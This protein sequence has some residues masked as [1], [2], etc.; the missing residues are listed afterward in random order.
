MVWGGAREFCFND[1]SE[2]PECR[3]FIN[4]YVLYTRMLSP[5]QQLR[6]ENGGKRRWDL[7][8]MGGGTVA[9]HR[10]PG[11]FLEPIQTQPSS[12]EPCQAQVKVRSCA[13]FLEIRICWGGL[14]LWLELLHPRWAPGSTDSLRYHSGAHKQGAWRKV[15]GA[16]ECEQSRRIRANSAVQLY[17]A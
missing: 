16:L 2:G 7:Q 17:G 3:C 10:R 1:C 8:G 4:T 9:G 5:P 15:D 14:S 11:N 12:T 13:L 6:Q